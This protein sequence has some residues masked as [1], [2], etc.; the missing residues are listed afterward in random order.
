MMCVLIHLCLLLVLN[1]GTAK[2]TISSSCRGDCGGISI[3]YPFGVGKGCFFNEWYEVTCN[4]STSGEFVPILSKINEEL[5]Q[6]SLPGPVSHMDKSTP[7]GSLRIKTSIASLGCSGS[8]D[9]IDKSEL[10]FDLTGSP[11]LISDNNTLVGFGC[12]IIA[13]LIHGKTNLIGCVSDCKDD[14]TRLDFDKSEPCDGYP[15]CDA[16][17][18]K[19]VGVVVGVSI[20]R[21]DHNLTTGGCG[22]AFL[23]DEYHHHQWQSSLRPSNYSAQRLYAG[24]YV[25]VE[26]T[27]KLITTNL[28]YQ[29]SL[30][31]NENPD[32]FYYNNP[33][34]CDS[35]ND[36]KLISTLL[37]CAC[38]RGYTGNPYVLNGCKDIDE[39]KELANICTNGGTCQNSPG[40]YRCEIRKSHTILIY[41]ALR[42][43]FFEQNGGGMLIHRLSGSGPPN[44][45]V[46]IFTEEAMKEA[47]N[48]Y[49]ESRILGQGGQGKVYKGILSD[50][51]IVAIKKARIGDSNQVEQFI[52]EV[53]ILSQVNHRN[54]V[55]LLGFCLETEIP[56]L[57]Y[58]YVANGT[59]Y[60]H[61]H[62]SKFDSLT[63]EDR[64]RIAVEV[65]GTLSYLHSS[66]SI[67]IIHRDIKTA[68]IL[69][70]NNLTSKVA[71][72]GASRMIPMDKEQLKTMVQGTIGYL[73]P[74]YYNTGL[75]NDKSDVFSFG[76][77]LMEL[78]SGQ[79][80]L[81]FERPQQSRHLVSYFASAK[82]ENRLHEVID[83][84]VMNKDNQREIQKAARIAVEC[85]RSTGEE[86]PR[87]KEVAA[88][89]EALKVKT[90]KHKLSDQNPE[91]IEHLLGGY[92]LSEQGDTSSSG[93]RLYQGR[94]L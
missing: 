29:K 48:N 62:G 55:K 12:N 68:N 86:R 83:G 27:W 56:L 52:N 8:N 41:V 73:D 54:V 17:I 90:T 28:S 18:P 7:L 13:A 64:L 42:Q 30:G 3:I 47:T 10:L 63:W 74:E 9:D 40:S 19:K 85:T 58:E 32:E 65:V 15:C 53:L 72:F 84:Q 6:I 93:S 61:L 50:N 25:N 79:M 31:C 57:V 80:P 59:L 49:D 21:Y 77:V 44:V 23:T 69:L 1:L 89:L 91:E 70:D 43:K 5:V 24:K 82:K 14:E 60:D 51:S 66:I 76:V 67:P 22:V 45:D 33:C 36:H 71:D 75:L 46:K 87:M 4:K 34:H 81:C 88:E 92:I 11:F 26:L 78:I 37:R 20:E 94:T 39:C 2:Q 38:T 35:F 16:N